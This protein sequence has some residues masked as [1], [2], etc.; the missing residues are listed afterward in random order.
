MR[1]SG[2]RPDELR[3]I[4]FS[5]NFTMHAEGAVLACFGNTQVLCTASVE[6]KVPPFLK[7]VRHAAAVDA[8][9]LAP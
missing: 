9:A 7:G 1:P 8:H 4:S 6:P 5:A 2:R 3:S